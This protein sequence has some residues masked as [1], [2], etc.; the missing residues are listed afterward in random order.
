MKYH[1]ACRVQNVPPPLLD[2]AVSA[3]T[4]EAPSYTCG[5]AVALP[6]G[7]H[8]AFRQAPHTNTAVA[9]LLGGRHFG[10]RMIK[11]PGSQP[12]PADNASSVC[13]ET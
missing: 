7:R 12:R 11:S 13:N 3:I 8:S 10:S 5:L 2:G 4:T 6:G 1:I 9:H